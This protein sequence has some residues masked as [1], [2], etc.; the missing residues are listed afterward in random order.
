[1]SSMDHWFHD[2]TRRRGDD[3]TTVRGCVR[4]PTAYLAP[5]A[6]VQV[7][8]VLIDPQLGDHEYTVISIRPELGHAGV[9][10]Q[11]AAVR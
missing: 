8:D 1:M 9:D 3:E 5:E 2:L 10:H 6:D 11:E 4:P 7:D